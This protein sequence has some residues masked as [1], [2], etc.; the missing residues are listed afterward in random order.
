MYGQCSKGHRLRWACHKGKPSLCPKCEEDRKAAEKKR[1]AELEAQK[2][3]EEEKR[4]HDQKMAELD[5]QLSEEVHLMRKLLES[6]KL[7]QPTNNPP[8]EPPQ[9]R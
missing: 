2:K 6:V 9:T 4:L 1:R 7:S 3:A 8:G 5:S